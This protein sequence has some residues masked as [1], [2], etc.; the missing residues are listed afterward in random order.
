[1][2]ALVDGREY[3]YRA[4]R[5]GD[6]AMIRFAAL[7]VAAS[8]LAVSVPSLADGIPIENRPTLTKK[9]KKKK[10]VRKKTVIEKRI[11]VEEKQAA[12]PVVPPSPP[13]PATP[14]FV[15]VPGH[16][17]WNAPMNMHVWVPGM[18]IRP[19]SPEE[20]RSLALRRIGKWIGID[21]QD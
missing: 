5:A 3:N 16:W 18:Y 14:V 9:I 17:T 15:W 1:M 19:P 12:P 13:P 8:V 11:V 4:T 7:L 21:R 20:E 10:I 6:F 2:I